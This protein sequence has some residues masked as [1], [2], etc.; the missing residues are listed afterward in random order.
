MVPRPDQAGLL[1]FQLPLVQRPRVHRAERADRQRLR[2]RRDDHRTSQRC[3]PRLRVTRSS[4]V[5]R[6]TPSHDTCVSPDTATRRLVRLR[7]RS[8]DELIAGYIRMAA[9]PVRKAEAI[10]QPA[11]ARSCQ[12]PTT[13]GGPLTA[14]LEP[15]AFDHGTDQPQRTLAGDDRLRPAQLQPE[16][17]AKPTTTAGRHGL[18]ASTSTSACRSSRAPTPRLPPQ[19][20]ATTVTLPEG[21]S[22]NPNAADGKTP[23]PTPQARFG[24]EDAADCPE[25]AK[26]GHAG[27]RQLR[28]ARADP[29]LHLPRRPAARQP[30]PDDP[31]RR[32]LRR[33]TSSCRA[34]SGPTRRPASSSTTFETCPQTP[35]DRVQPALLRLRA[36][37]LLATP[38]QC[39][40][41]PVR[42]HL[43]PPGTTALPEQTS[44][45]FFTIDSGPGGRPC[46]TATAP[47]R[48]RASRPA[49]PTTPPASHSPFGLALIARADGDQNL[50]GLDGDHRRRASR[51]RSKASPTARSRRIARWR[52]R[53]YTGLAELASPA[54]PAASQIGTRDRRRRRRQP[55]LY[56]AG[57]VYLA[58]PYKGAPL[59]LVVV[60]P[61][62]SGPYDLGN[63]AVRAGDPRRPASPHR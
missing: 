17:R 10:E 18:A 3:R 59:S 5:F 22:I 38:T 34:R 28:A 52:T 36:R 63:V 57:K 8:A 29:G 35:F 39:G 27:D 24:T 30:L 60:I 21:F 9:R 16:P 40:T 7:C 26:V 46:P 44:T 43:R 41:Y 62:V 20:K 4:G 15:L 47:V 1:R 37:G 25:F 56:V 31:H 2:A 42:D 54:C 45:Q 51:R 50:A 13:C 53:G 48:A 6:R 49:Q 11:S 58:G 55:P 33:P 32:R 23:A 19:I 61:A 14:T 12:N